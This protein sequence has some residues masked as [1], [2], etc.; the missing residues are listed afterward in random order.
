MSSARKIMF[1]P[2][3]VAKISEAAQT[4]RSEPVRADI[5]GF[6]TG[7]G[8]EMSIGELALRVIRQ[9]REQKQGE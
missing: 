7:T 1:T 8:R 3:A 9:A 6:E 2:V 5:L 4:L